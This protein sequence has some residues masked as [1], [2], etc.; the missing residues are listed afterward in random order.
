MKTT[1]IVIVVLG[2]ISLLGSMIGG[3]SATGPLFWLGLGIYLIHRANQKKQEQ[4][5]KDA[6]SNRQES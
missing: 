5:D 3:N 1:G 4:K 6:W 2:S